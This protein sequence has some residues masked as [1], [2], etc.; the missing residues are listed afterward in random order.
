MLSCSCSRRVR[1]QSQRYL[2]CQ[3]LQLLD[4]LLSD[5]T[6]NTG[7]R[8]LC[9][10]LM[11]NHRIYIAFDNDHLL[12][13]LDGVPGHVQGIEHSVFFKEQCLRRIE[14]L[15]LAIPQCA[16]AK[17][18][19]TSPYIPDGKNDAMP[20]VIIDPTTFTPVS[21]TLAIRLPLTP[22]FLRLPST[23][24]LPRTRIAPVA[25]QPTTHQFLLAIAQAQQVFA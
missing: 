25:C 21:Q 23:H 4:M 17:T 24:R 16:T 14:I 19:Y 2:L 11:S 13:Q 10:I 9:P 5:G 3:L 8:L 15:W 22:G 12:R 20:K 7:D 18:N 1:V 6:T